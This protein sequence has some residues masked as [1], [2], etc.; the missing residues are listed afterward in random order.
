ME[1]LRK[2][3]MKPNAPSALVQ[4]I[5]SPGQ[6]Q[7]ISELLEE[8]AHVFVNE[9]LLK[10]RKRKCA[11]LIKALLVSSKHNLGFKDLGEVLFYE[12][13]NCKVQ[14]PPNALTQE[15]LSERS[16][17]NALALIELPPLVNYRDLDFEQMLSKKA[18]ALG[19]RQPDIYARYHAEEPKLKAA[20]LT[21]KHYPNATPTERKNHRGK[22]QKAIDNRKQRNKRRPVA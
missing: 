11:R 7:Y 12:L 20:E 18:D 13:K 6:R 21:T 14:I 9:T 4:P 3:A 10:R 5:Q 1:R 22:F 2:A 19:K 15:R 8:A 16:R 17:M